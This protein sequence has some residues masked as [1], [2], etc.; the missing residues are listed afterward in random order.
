MILRA[1]WV[2]AGGPEGSRLVENGAVRIA[3]GLIVEVGPA[4]RIGSAGADDLGDCL[5]LPGFVNAHTHLELS[6]LA[7]RV[8]P[9]F[10]EATPG[11]DFVEWLDRLLAA[12]R[13]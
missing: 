7:G 9:G 13:A 4:P 5:L 2:L 8:Q 6:H 1:A 12:L 11:G 3:D 10:A